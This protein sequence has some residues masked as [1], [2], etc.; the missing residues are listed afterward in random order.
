MTMTMPTTINLYCWV[1]G[2]DFG[3]IFPVEITSTKTVGDLKKVIKLKKQSTFQDVDADTLILWKIFV[4]FDAN[5]E[6][7]LGV[8]DFKDVPRLMP[9]TKLSSLYSDQPTGDYLIVIKPPTR[10]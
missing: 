10:E 9:W 3:R 7:T 6:S 5:L 8:L 2:T 1:Q 4:D